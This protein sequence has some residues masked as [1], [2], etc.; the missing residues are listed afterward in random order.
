MTRMQTL[1]G[2]VLV[3]GASF[4]YGA[5]PVLHVTKTATV[6]APAAKV[7]DAVKNFDGLNTWHPA[8]ASDQIVEGKNNQV[9][10]VRLLTLKDGGTIKEKL[11]GYHPAGRSFKYAILEGVLPV[12]D[13][14][15]T[16]SVKAAKGGKS[17]VTWSGQFKRKN[18][19]DH[20]AAN[21]D[22]KTATDTMG[23][24]YQAGLD[25]LVKMFGGG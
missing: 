10:A 16:V 2:A 21:E 20:P 11:L 15:S 19:G 18:V 14:T 3:V 9:G 23:T 5:A 6:D 24:V 8:V 4:A 7:W 17:V 13:Y 22:D 12:S 25:N 1:L